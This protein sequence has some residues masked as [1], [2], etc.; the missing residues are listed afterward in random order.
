MKSLTPLSFLDRFTEAEQ[1]AIILSDDPQ[2]AVFRFK[3]CISDRVLSTD[4]RLEQGRTLLV[5]KGLI[6]AERAEAIFNFQ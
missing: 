2:V 6:S 3:F 1:T 5:S 4:P